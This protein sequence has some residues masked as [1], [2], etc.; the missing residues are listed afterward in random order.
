M[1]PAGVEAAR[2][3][4]EAVGR[5]IDDALVAVPDLTCDRRRAGVT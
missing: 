1:A 5:L 4:P 3:T 2:L